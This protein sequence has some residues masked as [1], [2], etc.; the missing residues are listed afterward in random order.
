[1]FKNYD[2]SK[3]YLVACSGGPD[4]MAL[5]NMLLN[6]SFN[7]IVAH[8]NYK[9]R[10]ES[11]SEEAL[12]I[13]YCKKHNIKVYV[14]TFNHAYKGNFEDVARKFRYNFF[15]EIY[16]KNNCSGLF[17]AHHKDDLIETY[18][19]KKQRN[20]INESFLI[21]EKTIINKMNVFRPL[22]LNFYKEDLLK[23]C[24]DNNI[25]YGIDKTNF[26]DIHTRNIIRKNL[27]NM[28]KEE[29]Y[30]K[31]LKE[32]DNLIKTRQSVKR[33]IKFYPVYLVS[34]LK[35]KDDLWLSIFL[36]ELADKK[37]KKYVNK[38][39]LLT[40]KDFIKSDK[41]NLKY[42]IN[43]NYYLIKNYN[44][45]SYIAKEDNS[46]EYIL[47]TLDFIT[48][49]QFKIVDNG[50]KMHGVYVEDSD[51]PIVIRTYKTDDKIKLKEGSKKVS[52]L[53]IDKKV[54]PLRRNQII[55]IENKDHEIIFVY[56]LYRKYGQK[57]LKNNMFF[58]LK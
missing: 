8:V 18:L 49:K 3:T 9:T 6:D 47:E 22:L 26:M 46:F 30:Q 1:M 12:V 48:T 52:R 43:S 45:I 29:I 57:Y 2:K 15:S 10:D 16:L 58:K 17:V 7:V 38:S 40:L 51:F 5:L 31:A 14:E 34:D 37:F 35:E 39:L 23:Y 32:E 28:D 20:V 53:F 25:E 42:N 21:K 55:V 4:S 50:L 24:S 56:G 19:L 27:L 44:Q 33:F 41:T 11:D 13:N 54:P 36:Y